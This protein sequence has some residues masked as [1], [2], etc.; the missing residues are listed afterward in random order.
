MKRFD[1]QQVKC[2]QPSRQLLNKN[3]Q[4]SNASSVHSIFEGSYILYS[5]FRSI[6]PFV[7]LGNIV[8]YYIMISKILCFI[9]TRLLFY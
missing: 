2:I 8:H 5:T 1:G 4:A 6:V 9:P 7:A 3:A